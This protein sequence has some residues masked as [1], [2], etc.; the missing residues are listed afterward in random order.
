VKAA[1]REQ[2][3]RARELGIFGGPTFFAAGQMYW[4]NDRLEDA[5]EQAAA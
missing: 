5:L 3:Q 2:T 4:G 1:L